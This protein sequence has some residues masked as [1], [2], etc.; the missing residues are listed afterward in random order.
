MQDRPTPRTGDAGNAAAPAEPMAANPLDAADRQIVERANTLLAEGR[1]GID[2]ACDELRAAVAAQPGLVWARTRLGQ[3]LNS[4][5]EFSASVDILIP[6]A[7]KPGTPVELYETL[8]EA[9]TCLERMDDAARAALLHFLA[10]KGVLSRQDTVVDS[11]LLQPSGP[12]ATPPQDAERPVLEAGVNRLRHCRHGAMLFNRHDLVIG[13]SLDAYGEYAEREMEVFEQVVREGSVA[14]DV[15]ANVGG[16][17]VRLAQLVGSEG[18]VI[19]FEPQRV[20]FQTLCANAALNGLLNV[21]CYW[22]AVGAAPGRITLPALDYARP[23]NFGAVSLEA[24]RPESGTGESVEVRT[25]DGFGLSHCEFMKIDVEG[26]EL[27]VLRGATDTIRRCRPALYVENNQ[28]DKSAA[29]V[30]FLRSMGYRL[31]WH[32]APFYNPA[33]YYGNPENVIPLGV[34]RNMLCLHESVSA[35]LE[36]LVPVE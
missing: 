14:L 21:H 23:D 3:L 35:T 36:G 26:M 9:L 4:L 16:H 27:D 31:Y 6:A 34:D 29:L 1:T 13:R 24:G 12:P 18:I 10:R 30:G 2:K 22:A 7:N 32:L 11:S 19:A 15:G 20:T 28:K 17:T 8:T 33:N 5:G 25:I